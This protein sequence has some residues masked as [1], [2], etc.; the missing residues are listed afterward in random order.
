MTRP[1]YE[2]PEDLKREAQIL[3]RIVL[4]TNAQ[5]I[6]L[7]IRD[8][9]DYAMYRNGELLALIEIKTRNAKHAAFDTYMLEYSKAE[10]ARVISFESGVPCFLFVQWQD[11][12]GFCNFANDFELG[13]NG[14]K[15]RH[16]EDVG[17]VAYYPIDRFIIIHDSSI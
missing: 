9:L 3:E 17:L 5:A 6:K 2:T 1:L 12:L 4:W 11:K 13:V 14:R 8:H 15:D 10:K 16:T 7:A